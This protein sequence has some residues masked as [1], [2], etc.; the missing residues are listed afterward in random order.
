MYLFANIS[1]SRYLNLSFFPITIPDASNALIALSGDI[2]K[3][4]GRPFP[5]DAFLPSVA[6]YKK[7]CY[8]IR[9]PV[10][11]SREGVTIYA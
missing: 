1:V 6:K 2:S 8:L 10:A 4:G 3:V 5:S 7:I 9:R 11:I